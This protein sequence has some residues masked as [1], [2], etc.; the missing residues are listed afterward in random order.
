MKR[1]ENYRSRVNSA[2]PLIHKVYLGKERERRERT[3]ERAKYLHASN[4][5][6]K[7]KIR[8][9]L[10]RESSFHK[11]ISTE[12]PPARTKSHNKR[13]FILRTL[14]RIRRRRVNHGRATTSIT[15]QPSKCTAAPREL[16]TTSRVASRE[17]NI[18]QYDYL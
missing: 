10:S 17:G 6:K 14:S 8:K 11:S 18:I 12:K 7:F 16:R 15:A 1:N 4:K 2:K 5:G 9:K 13:K 3:S